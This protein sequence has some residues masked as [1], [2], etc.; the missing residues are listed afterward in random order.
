MKCFRCQHIQSSFMIIIYLTISHPIWQDSVFVENNVVGNKRRCNDKMVLKTIKFGVVI[1][2]SH[3]LVELTIPVFP[4]V[5]DSMTK[6]GHRDPTNMA[7]SCYKNGTV[8]L[9]H[10]QIWEMSAVQKSLSQTLSTCRVREF[11]SFLWKQV[12]SLRLLVTKNWN[13]STG[14]TFQSHSS[15]F[16]AETVSRPIWLHMATLW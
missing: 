10:P 15:Y 1:A 4:P 2:Y 11:T 13:V 8:A 9:N 7:R 12:I 3:W 6:N 16:H 14:E 5:H